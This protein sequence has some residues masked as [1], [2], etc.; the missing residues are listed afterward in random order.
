MVAEVEEKKTSTVDE[1]SKISELKGH[2]YELIG[3]GTQ[4]DQ[5][6]KTTKAIGEYVGHVYGNAMKKLVIHWVEKKPKEPDYL[7]SAKPSEKENGKHD[8][9]LK[10]VVLFESIKKLDDKQAIMECQRTR[11]KRSQ[12]RWVKRELL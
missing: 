6:T 12:T 3:A 9:Q 5:Y 2:Q 1:F 7:G 10:G 4:A 11:H 8:T